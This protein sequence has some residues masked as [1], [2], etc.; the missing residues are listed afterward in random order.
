MNNIARRQEAGQVP[1]PLPSEM[2]AFLSQYIQGQERAL[3]DLA[4]I[5]YEHLYS[6]SHRMN[7]PDEPDE[8]GR[9]GLMMIG[10]TGSGKTYSLEILSRF[11]SARGIPVGVFTQAATSLVA[12]GYRGENIDSVLANLARAHPTGPVILVLNE[13]DKKARADVELDIAGEGAQDGLLP[14][15]DAGVQMVRSGNETPVAIDMRRILVVATG[16]FVGLPDMIRDRVHGKARLGFDASGDR[17]PPMSD[18]AARELLLP[19]DLE[20]FLKRELVGRFG[21]LTVFHPLTEAE[22]RR[23]IDGAKDSP[24]AQ[25]VRLFAAHGVELVFTDGARDALARTAVRLQ[26]G[27]RGVDSVLR[28]VL[29]DAQY[30]LTALYKRGIRQVRVTPEAIEGLR[31]PQFG[32]A[33]RNG[34]DVAMRILLLPV[35]AGPRAENEQIS[36]EATRA[37]MVELRAKVGFDSAPIHVRRWWRSFEEEFATRPN[38]VIWLVEELLSRQATVSEFCSA[39]MVSECTN[40]KAILHFLDYLRAKNGMKRDEGDD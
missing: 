39:A 33:K 23:L 12:P 17:R 38:V 37:R 32:R 8:Y 5:V 22:L 28:R 7:H 30:E 10:P 34:A 9:T 31:R 20:P 4:N 16:A 13:I 19:E 36:G 2:V 35:S 24:L 21:V 1:I 18:E 11:L 26:T 40:L 15:F 3:R 25:R 29:R 6:F 14:L 27:V